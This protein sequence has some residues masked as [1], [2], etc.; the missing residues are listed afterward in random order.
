MSQSA[1]RNQSGLERLDDRASVH[2]A[3]NNNKADSVLASERT[4][5]HDAEELE[6]DEV[7]DLGRYAESVRSDAKE[8]RGEYRLEDA[9]D[10]DDF[11]DFER[12]TGAQRIDS[13]G[14]VN[15]GE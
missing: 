8:F 7:D 14:A 5:Q 15:R 11:G 4:S 2:G 1:W 10:D 6:M 9:V 3:N 12:A 13:S